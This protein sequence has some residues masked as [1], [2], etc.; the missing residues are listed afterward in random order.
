[1]RRIGL[2][3]VA[4]A[5]AMGGVARGHDNDNSNVQLVVQ[6]AQAD[7]VSRTLIIE[8]QWLVWHD[9]RDVRV[10]LA[11]TPLVVTSA[12]RSQVRAQLPAGLVP[13]HYLLKV[14]RGS[15]TPES[16]AFFLT[17][18]A[19]GLTGPPGPQGDK[20]DGDK[21]TWGPRDC[22]ARRDRR[23]PPEPPEPPERDAR[24]GQDGQRRPRRDR[25]RPRDSRAARAGGHGRSRRAALLWLPHRRRPHPRLLERDGDGHVL[26]AGLA[27]GCELPGI[28]HLLGSER[29]GQRARG[30]SVRPDG[31]L[32]AGRL[33]PAHADGLRSDRRL[34]G[35]GAGLCH[36]RLG[37][38]ALADQQ[39]RV[40]LPQCRLH[41]VRWGAVQ[42]PYWTSTP[43]Q[44]VTGLA[45]L[46]SL[47]SGTLTESV[48]GLPNL[49]W[50]V[51][52]QR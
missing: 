49:T 22:L 45:Y 43:R 6:K 38:P 27:Q 18:G 46:M 13:G 23:A 2:L 47:D 7:V 21:A 9:A 15:G 11:G 17:I 52:G 35:G 5:L 4:G 8:G 32:V 1:M 25:R 36:R 20:G 39:R 12:T 31:R 48:K 19:S 29:S 30:R 41:A 16:D 40:R 44:D 34:G 24:D 10:S 42:I 50:A 26:G 37:R 51:R 3:C 33:A 14:W 28:A